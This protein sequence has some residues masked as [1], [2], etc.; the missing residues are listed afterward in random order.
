[1]KTISLHYFVS[2]AP[3]KSDDS[4]V[5]TNFF[6]ANQFVGSLEDGAFTYHDWDE[7]ILSDVPE[8]MKGQKLLTT[9]R[10]RGVESWLAGV[11]R[12]TDYPSSKLPDQVMLT[13]S[14]DPGTG[15]DIQWR[16]DTVHE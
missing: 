12:S 10:G 14:S 15:I 7:L 6:P 13:W 16:T 1:M 8:K 11:F 5:L 3:Q 4:L 9:V 2:V